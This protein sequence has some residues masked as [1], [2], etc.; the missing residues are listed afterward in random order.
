[1]SLQKDGGGKCEVG[2]LSTYTH[3]YKYM[4]KHTYITG[5]RANLDY[6]RLINL[7]TRTRSDLIK[8]EF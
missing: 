7:V 5:L 1:M 6:N 8:S 3:I 4:C 2:E